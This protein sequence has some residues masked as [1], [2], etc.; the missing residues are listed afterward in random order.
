MRYRLENFELDDNQVSLTCDG[1]SVHIEPQVFQLLAYL[2]ENRDRVVSKEELLD[3]IWGSRFVSESALTTRV[4]GLR[5]AL[6][7]DG[8]AQRLIRTV[9]GTGYQYVGPVEEVDESYRS[10][11]APAVPASANT[12]RGREAEIHDLV[13]L[14]DESRL[15]TVVGPGGTGK[16]RLSLEIIARQLQGD[17]R[18]SFVE[19]ST[20]R[21]PEAIVEALEAVLAV[22]TGQ[23]TGPLDACC[24]YLSTGVHLLI[25]DNCEHVLDPA[26]D[27]VGELLARCDDLTIVATSREP[28]GLGHEQV[29]RLGP[30]GLPSLDADL[31]ESDYEQSPAVALFVDRAKRVDQGFVVTD[32]ALGKIASLCRSLDGLPLA[33]EL[34]AGRTGV[35]G[36][37]DLIDRLDRRLDLLGDERGAVDGRH[38]TL[39][40]TLEWS[41]DLLGEEQQRLY[42]HMAVFPDGVTLATVEWLAKAIDLRE[43]P[44]LALSRLVEASVLVRQSSASG[45]R[46]EQLETVRAFGRDRLEHEGEL[47]VARQLLADWATHVTQPLREDTRTPQEAE[48]NQ[49]IRDE[50]AN[51]RSAR[52]VMLAN[53]LLSQAVGLSSSLDEWA[54]LRDISE[55][56]SWSKELIDLVGDTDPVLLARIKATAAHGTWRRGDFDSCE[57]LSQEALAVEGID[58]WTRARANSALAVADLFRGRLDDAIDHWVASASFDGNPVDLAAAALA[59][60]YQ[61]RFDRADELLDL[62]VENAGPESPAAVDSWIA[63]SRGESAA[64]QGTGNHEVYL[65]RAI[66]LAEESGVTFTAGVARLTLVSNS[67][68]EP[69]DPQTARD[70]AELVDLWLRSG[71]WTQLWTTLRNAAGFLAPSHPE[72]A[73]LML[74][75]ADNDVFA[76]LVSDE[77]AQANESRRESLA[78]DVGSAAAG[79]TQRAASMDRTEVV[80]SVLLAL[81]SLF[82]EVDD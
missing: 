73:L 64:V 53:G 72:T 38:R 79:I 43:E 78:A 30:L 81:R 18:A 37:D 70:Y 42:R 41:Y 48:W 40:A 31:A 22:Q 44:L 36:L 62:A 32:D 82:D 66:E 45:V 80:E 61:G 21:Q 68:V 5:Q 14:L 4:K 12:L 35:F 65:R 77:V 51:L 54:R 52:Q 6:G 58:D 46:Y 33:I 55:I 15:V 49:I 13:G 19:L 25:L 59:A 74:V 34:A 75:A 69:G 56:W 57:R 3:S 28:L 2:V 76:P 71:T 60:A 17:R 9:H 10:P 1:E 20:V 8:R 67:E 23:R 39:R 47:E 7:D 29:Y 26:S 11:S 27:L 16:T 50:L 63:Y 24:E